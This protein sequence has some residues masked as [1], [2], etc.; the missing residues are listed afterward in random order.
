MYICQ[1]CNQPIKDGDHCLVLRE[2]ETNRLVYVAHAACAVV[3][4][5]E[6]IAKG[7][8]DDNNPPRN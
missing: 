2:K 6:K 8:N 3:E 1:E 7:E 4:H 5:L